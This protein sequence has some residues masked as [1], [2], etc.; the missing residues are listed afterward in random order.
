MREKVMSSI[1]IDCRYKSITIDSSIGIDY[2]RL[3]SVTNF[4][5]LQVT[6]MKSLYII[7]TICLYG[8][9]ESFNLHSM[10][11]FYNYQQNTRNKKQ[12]TGPFWS[13]Y[14]SSCIFASTQFMIPEEAAASSGVHGI[15]NYTL[16]SRFPNFPCLEDQFAVY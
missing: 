5:F 10:Q 14:L 8:F 9:I 3:L 2:Y 6:L 16:S 1:A 4:V 13:F 15:Q 12:L 7:N 11:E